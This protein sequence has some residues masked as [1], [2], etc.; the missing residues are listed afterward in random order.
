MFFYQYTQKYTHI[1]MY[2]KR[3][4][5]EPFL[6]LYLKIILSLFGS[7]FID[8][9][10]TLSIK[11]HNSITSFCFDSYICVMLSIPMKESAKVKAHLLHFNWSTISIARSFIAFAAYMLCKLL[12][13]LSSWAYRLSCFI[14]QFSF[15]LFYVFIYDMD[16]WNI[17]VHSF[18]KVSFRLSFLHF[19]NW[20]IF[21]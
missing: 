12:L 7:Q 15:I 3:A 17:C 10:Q 6:S 21:M 4:Y 14:M 8:R 9:N 5:I 20:H 1:Y 16:V 18:L 19:S 13:F 2:S 11:L